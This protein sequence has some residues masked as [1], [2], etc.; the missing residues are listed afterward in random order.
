MNPQTVHLKP[1]KSAFRDYT[2]FDEQ[3][4]LKD[5]QSVELSRNSDCPNENCNYLT[6]RFLSIVNKHAPLKTKII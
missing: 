4:F 6:C 5:L 3:Y 2:H 1:Q